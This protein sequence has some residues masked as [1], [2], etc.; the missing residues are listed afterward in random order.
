[1]KLFSKKI[2]LAVVVCSLLL[3]GYFN[4]ALLIHHIFALNSHHLLVNQPE[5]PYYLSADVITFSYDRPMQLYAFLE[6]IE[7]HV[8]GQGKMYVVYR[9]SSAEYKKG[10]S[11]V[12]KRFPEV[13]F[14]EQ[15]D[16]LENNFKSLVLQAIKD[17]PSDFLI[18]A[19]DD[20]IITSK[21]DI[22]HSVK[23]MI[24]HRAYAFLFRMG[25]NIMYSNRNTPLKIPY[26]TI[27]EEDMRLWVVKNGQEAWH[28][29]HNVD[30][31]MYSKKEI[32]PVLE[33]LS[34]IAPN[35]FEEAWNRVCFVSL[36]GRLKDWTKFNFK[37]CLCYSKSKLINIPIN[38]VN[39]EIVNPNLSQSHYS[40]EALLSLFFDGVTIDVDAYHEYFPQTVH[41]MIDPQ[42]NLSGS[43][44][45]FCV[46]K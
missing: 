7:K 40:K 37:K 32:L 8:S 11:E 33:N 6:S 42:F 13:V 10:Y 44:G 18:F 35:S 43:K 20:D 3:L 9:V 25:N 39:E 36:F 24:D 21:I 41:V 22:S 45:S 19:V 34:F 16:S 4:K 14:L 26:Q 2:G 12:Q 46:E 17:S 1:M 27:P 5:S 30:F 29:V 15:G 23:A 38:L 28:Y 31:S